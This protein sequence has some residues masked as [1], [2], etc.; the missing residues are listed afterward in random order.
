[1]APAPP[2]QLVSG[3]RYNLAIGVLAAFALAESSSAG[4]DTKASSAAVAAATGTAGGGAE[5]ERAAAAASAAAAAAAGVGPPAIEDGTLAVERQRL[6]RGGEE[7]IGE[8][9][10][11]RRVQLERQHCEEESLVVVE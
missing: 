4:A 5:Y 7:T 6:G 8:V 9:I 11:V 3:D 10:T 1:M 2:Y